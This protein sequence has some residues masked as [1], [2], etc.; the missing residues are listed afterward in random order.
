[1]KSIKV[2]LALYFSLLLSII[3]LGLC[4]YGYKTGQKNMTTLA[5]QQSTMKVKSDINA[6]NTLIKQINGSVELKNGELVDLHGVP[7]KG[8]YKVVDLIDRELNDQATI[9]VKDGDEFIRI[10][11]NIMQEDGTR[12][13]GTELDKDSEEYKMAIIGEPYN[14]ASEVNGTKYQSAYLPLK[15]NG[16]K[17]IGLLSVAVPMTEAM[18]T[19]NTAITQMGKI[20][21]IF[22]GGCLVA[23]I[24][25]VLIIGK[26][27][28]S[29]LKK[30]VVFSKNIQ[31]LDVSKDVPVK[32]V[33]LKDEV[34]QV[35][36]ALEMIVNN[37]REF[38]KKT[39][40]LSTK[41][42]DYSESLSDNIEQVSITA[43]EIANVV[44]QIADGASKQAKKTEGGVMKAIRL[45]EC[46]EEN[47]YLLEILT[48]AMEE[49]EALR[50]E[51]L[52]SIDVLSRES[53][54]TSNASS[55]IYEVITNTNIKAKE[56]EKASTM[57]QDIAEQT[58]LLALNAAIE[59][60]RAGESGKGFA[61]VADEVRKLA[62]QS[63]KFTEQ[64]RKII[65]ELTKR[66]ESAVETMD[67]MNSVIEHQ[68]E[69]V[70]MTADKFNGIS[71]SVDKSLDS[72]EKLSVSSMSMESEKDDMLDIMNNLSAIA[73]ENAASTEEVAASVQEQTSIIFEFNESVG[74][75]VDLAKDMKTNIQK[76]KY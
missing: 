39:F 62:E 12:L 47:K 10:S 38:M 33:E 60:A 41:V 56:I 34:G 3:V 29:G 5:D 20:Y 11:T 64:I 27:I 63:T 32:L 36:K 15:D 69:S 16:G 31:E 55:Q 50:K 72:L 66:T 45:G 18:D 25:L 49:V 53:K 8:Y 43:N 30:I 21:L 46:I 54:E 17:V 44:V 67:I 58:N 4:I 22:G 6:F 23:A 73:E 9:F 14:G 68:T 42:T 28:T 74:T 65:K 48:T 76:F 13:E 70:E 61:V 71:K 7:L 40:N 35:A 75:M 24:I 52:E 59:A 19:V 2:K 51:G 26:N 1:M 57:I 37:L